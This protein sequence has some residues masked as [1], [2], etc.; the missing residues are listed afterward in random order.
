MVRS[1]SARLCRWSICCVTPLSTWKSVRQFLSTKRES[2]NLL[3][4]LPRTGLE[5]VAR[6]GRHGR[7]G[8]GP[9]VGSS[10]LSSLELGIV[11]V[12]A[13]KQ[14]DLLIRSLER[15]GLVLP[16]IP[17]REFRGP[18]SFAWAGPG[19]WLAM[20]ESASGTD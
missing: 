16:T 9:G 17:R 3:E 20:L 10:S 5:G 19:K 14:A 6:P 15:F 13:G 1:V 18:V 7:I 11:M 2:V 8:G 4:L 12:R